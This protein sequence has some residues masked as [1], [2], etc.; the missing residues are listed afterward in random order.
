MMTNIYG[1][2]VPGTVLS[3]LVLS[4]LTVMFL[5]VVFFR[6]L[7]LGVH[8]AFQICGFIIFIKFCKNVVIISS[9]IFS[10]PTRPSRT[11]LYIC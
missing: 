4:K 3:S 2:F 8:E 6:F 11:Q 9:N 5:G 10:I 1:I 7:L